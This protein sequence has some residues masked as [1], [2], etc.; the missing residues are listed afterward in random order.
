MPKPQYPTK[1]GIW[2]NGKRSEESYDN[3]QLGMPY[4]E[5]VENLR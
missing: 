1:K 3:V 2:S 4:P 5:A